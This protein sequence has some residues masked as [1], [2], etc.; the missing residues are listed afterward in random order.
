M[1]ENKKVIKNAMEAIR[2][3]ATSGKSRTPRFYLQPRRTVI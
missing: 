3:K 2:G 1:E